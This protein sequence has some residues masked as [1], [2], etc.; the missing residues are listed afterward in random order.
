MEFRDFPSSTELTR[1][2]L[3]LVYSCAKLGQEFVNGRTSEKGG[4]GVAKSD[5]TV[6]Y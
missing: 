5:E 6:Q 4:M 3:A 1:S 2:K